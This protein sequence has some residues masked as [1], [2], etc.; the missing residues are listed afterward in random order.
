ME[1]KN[2]IKRNKKIFLIAG[3]LLIAGIASVI[4]L[5]SLKPK[6]KIY[7]LTPKK[8]IN[9]NF[10]V[11]E[12]EGF[13]TLKLFEGESTVPEEKGRENPFEKYEVEEPEEEEEEEEPSPTPPEEE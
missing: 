9:I 7:S 3:S 10:E 2:P 13:K 6:G 8:K 4:F 11:F 5:L 1:I 12:K